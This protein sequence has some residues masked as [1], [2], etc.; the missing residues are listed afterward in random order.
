MV[1]NYTKPQ[2]VAEAKA[3]LRASV[4]QIDYL[5]PLRK[6]PWPVIGIGLVGGFLFHRASKKNTALTTGLFTL[7]MELARKW[8]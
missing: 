8:N 3:H 6:N 1:R 5:E 7:G 4:A 2:T